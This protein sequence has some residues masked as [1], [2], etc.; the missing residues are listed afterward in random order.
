MCFGGEGSFKESGT[1]REGELSRIKAALCVANS[2]IE[3]KLSVEI[4]CN[5]IDL[6]YLATWEA[7]DRQPEINNIRSKSPAEN[8]RYFTSCINTIADIM[9]IVYG[10]NDVVNDPSLIMK[11]K[12]SLLK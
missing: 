3:K 10:N 1:P 8:F 5:T 4:Q 9:D 2:C 6:P 12:T 7:R 11:H